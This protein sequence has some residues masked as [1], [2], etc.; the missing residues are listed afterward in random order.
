M[1]LS[2]FKALYIPNLGGFL[3]VGMCIIERWYMPSQHNFNLYDSYG[4]GELG[5]MNYY[6]WAP[7]S[8]NKHFRE[9]LSVW[10]M[11]LSTETLPIIPKNEPKL[12]TF[13]ITKFHLKPNK[14]IMIIIKNN[15][16]MTECKEI[17]VVF[18]CKRKNLRDVCHHFH[19]IFGHKNKFL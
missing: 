8:N 3:T 7:Y 12:N 13:Y 10:R 1:Q 11:C 18:V 9:Q 16:C 15:T 14:W 6:N 5:Q 2:V 17:S 4:L 19:A